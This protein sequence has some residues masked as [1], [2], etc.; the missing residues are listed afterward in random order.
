MAVGPEFDEAIGMGIV[1]PDDRIRAEGADGCGLR[2]G[3]EAVNHFLAVDVGLMLD[4]AAE[5]VCDRLGKKAEDGREQE[6][7]AQG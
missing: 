2:I 5:S 6:Q 1:K 4:V 3:N 7:Q